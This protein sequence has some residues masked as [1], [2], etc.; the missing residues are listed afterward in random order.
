MIRKRKSIIS[1]LVFF[2]VILSLIFM[3]FSIDKKTNKL[4]TDYIKDYGWKIQ[5]NPSEISHIT[6]PSEFDSVYVSYNKI[7]KNAGFDLEE[8]K[9]KTVTRYTYKVFNHKKSLEED[10]YVSVILYKDKIIASDIS[11]NGKVPFI[12]EI[13]NTSELV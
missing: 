6:I 3:I 13:S 5:E 11:S 10:V 8:Y 1:T 4:V 12:Y 2:V 7:Q 9:G